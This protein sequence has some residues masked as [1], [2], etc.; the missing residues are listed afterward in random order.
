MR[1]HEALLAMRLRGKTTDAVWVND[2]IDPAKCWQDW[3]TWANDAHVEILPT[4]RPKRLDTRFSAGLTV[5]LDSSSP[6]RLAGLTAAFLSGGASRVVGFLMG[7]DRRGATVEQMTDTQ[8]V[9]TW[10]Q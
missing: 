6:E 10:H 1:G 3:P 2:G 9:A 8:G 7:R 5:Y 4:D